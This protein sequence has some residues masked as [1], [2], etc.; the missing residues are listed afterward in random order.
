MDDIRELGVIEESVSEAV[1]I[2][3]SK[4]FRDFH[5]YEVKDFSLETLYRFPFGIWFRGQANKEDKLTPTI[6]RRDDYDESSMF[7][8]FQAR[9]TEYRNSY[10]SVFEWLCLMQHYGLPTRL[11]DWSESVLVALFFAAKGSEDSDGRVY[12]LNARR[13]NFITNSRKW[14]I[15]ERANV[16]APGSLNVV[17]RAHLAVTRSIPDWQQRMKSLNDRESWR[18]AQAR[19]IGGMKDIDSDALATPIAV[20]PGR[21]NGRMIFQSSSF[22]LHGGKKYLERKDDPSFLPEPKRIEDLDGEQ[23]DPSRKFIF[24]LTVKREA[25]PKVLRELLLLGLHPGSLFPEIDRQAEY[26]QSF[27]RLS[28][29]D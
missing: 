21:L 16:C 22:T 11:L 9:A 10:Q 17:A 15:R 23:A 14:D 6:F 3:G 12:I 26:I 25:K 29:L 20:L 1:T 7:N 24:Y 2:L 19:K 28:E 13:L 5:R 27:W 4:E 8:H 18:K